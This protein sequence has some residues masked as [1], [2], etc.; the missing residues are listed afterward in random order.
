M[1][2]QYY[3]S[4]TRM[5]AKGHNGESL[6]MVNSSCLYGHNEELALDHKT[7]GIKSETIAQLGLL[8]LHKV[9][10]GRYSFSCLYVILNYKE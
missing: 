9:S 6:E 1:Y 7:N 2:T 8:F 4:T 10:R 5:F 3:V